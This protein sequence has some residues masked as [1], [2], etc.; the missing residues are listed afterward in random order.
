MEPGWQQLVDLTQHSFTHNAPQQGNVTLLHAGEGP[1]LLHGRTRLTPG[2]DGGA[3]SL[4]V[5]F[6]QDRREVEARMRTE[7]LASM[8]RMSAAVAHEIR[9]PLAAITQANALLEEDLDQPRQRQLTQMVGQNAKRL[10]KIV[11]D[12]LNLSARAAGR[13]HPATRS[14][15]P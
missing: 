3:E 4:C 6:L 11:E 8:G 15:W 10:E 13:R 12:V 1:R 9:N 14:R 5:V 7:K 2:R